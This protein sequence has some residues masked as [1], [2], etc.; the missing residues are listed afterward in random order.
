MA[1]SE[2]ILRSRK[3]S[4]TEATQLKFTKLLLMMGT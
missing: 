4:K 3:S 1:L 2:L